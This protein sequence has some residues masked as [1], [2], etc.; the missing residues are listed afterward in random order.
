MS[1]PR[2]PAAARNARRAMRRGLTSSALAAATLSA[3]SD[4]VAPDTPAVNLK[5]D[6]VGA[7]SSQ[8]YDGVSDDLLTAG[9]G[10]SGLQSATAPGIADANQPTAAELRRLA[11]YNNYRALVDIAANGGYG[12]LYGPNVRNDGTATAHEGLIAGREYLAYADDG[13]GRKNVTMA[14]QVPAAFD[15]AH[16]CI[17]T[18]VSS[19]SRGVYGAIATSGEWGLKQ[20]CAVAYSDKG[21]GMG[22]DDVQNGTVN[23]ID[24]TRA[25]L[26]AAG[27][28]AHFAALLSPT[29]RANFN[30]ARPYRFAFKHAH[31]QQNPEKDWGLDTLQAIQFAFYVLN[32]QYGAALPDGRHLRRYVPANTLVLAAGVSNGGG[33][34][35]AAAEQDDA[36]WIDGVVVSE[37][38]IQLHADDRV[39]VVRAGEVRIGTGKTLYD[40]FTVANL[41]QPCAALAAAAAGSPGADFINAGQAANRCAALRSQGLLS[42]DALAAQADEALAALHAAGW[43]AESDVLQA[44]HYAFAVP[45]VTVS[46]ANAYARASVADDLCG[47]SFAATAADGTV[48]AYSSSALQRLFGTGNGVPPTAGIGIVND[49]NPGGPLL[50]SASRSPSSGLAD[51]N[52]DGA[53]CLRALLTENDQIAQALQAGIDEVRH[54][55]NLH[56]KPALIVQGRSD[57]LIPV[58]N[59]S[60]P[61][62]GLNQLVEGAGSQLRYVEVTNANHFDSFIDNPALPGYDRLLIP[63]HVYFIRELNAMYA[64]LTQGQALP[65]SQVLHTF[66]RGGTAGA[67]P[68]LT[69]ANVPPFS[70]APAADARIGYTDGTV[71]IPE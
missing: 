3:C 55:G 42:S 65:P 13:S 23:L 19:G 7:V 62:F 8:Q 2:L 59:A 29:E 17:V 20:G 12:S 63:L 31:S 30:A 37:P 45:A 36:G 18:A 66:P 56:G 60:R 32:E 61:Y 21:S 57:T 67:A 38:Q 34:A 68:P 11:I 5:P 33:A 1:I 27:S 70:L 46:Y 39:R 25:T 41:Y 35:L 40:Y 10:K 51:Y 28:A 43:Q 52:T 22:V 48:Q 16:P 14:V 44:S 69:A 64:H 47:Y 24:G 50:D 49:R 9:L 26:D 71:T 4:V 15:T 6:F 58:A 54:S 53:L